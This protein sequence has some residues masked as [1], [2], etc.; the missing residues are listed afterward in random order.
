MKNTLFALI[1][2]LLS[3]IAHADIYKCT[4]AID[5]PIFVDSK[6]KENYKNCTLMVRDQPSQKSAD[7]GPSNKSTASPRNFPR[8][9]KQ[10]QSQRDDKRKQILL[11]ELETEQK[12]L[13]GAKNEGKPAE[14][15]LHEKNIELLKKEV[16][17]LK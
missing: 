13:T 6:T 1:L 7:D 16:G 17:A 3:T 10:V 9:D 11:S 2:L 5:S 14:A 8:V 12:A 4:S 15:N